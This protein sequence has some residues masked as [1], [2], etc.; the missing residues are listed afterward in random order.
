[1]PAAW[2][3]GLDRSADLLDPLFCRSKVRDDV[4][5]GPEDRPGREHGGADQD[6]LGR[7]LAEECELA[8]GS[9]EVTRRLFGRWEEWCRTQAEDPGTS[10]SFTDGL[11]RLKLKR[12]R[13][14][15]TR[16]WGFRGIALAHNVREKDQ[17]DAVLAEA[18]TAGAR[19]V[20]PAQDAFWGGRSAY[21]ADPEGNL[22][23]VAWAPTFKFDERGAL[24]VP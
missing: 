22:W 18:Q 23:E 19:I 2:S 6:A 13:H 15:K 8:P 21:F 4:G 16:Q 7:W 10:R 17:V 9:A 24:I 20:K 1:M 12:W 14:P 3:H 5:Q 11:V